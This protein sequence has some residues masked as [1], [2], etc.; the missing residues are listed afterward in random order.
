MELGD[1]AVAQ[2]VTEP[3]GD[4]RPTC[5]RRSA[6]SGARRATSVVL[7]G[8]ARH[9][10]SAAPSDLFGPNDVSTFPPD[11]TGSPSATSRA[12]RSSGMGFRAW[13]GFPTGIHSRVLRT[14]LFTDLVDSTQIA[15]RL[16]DARWRELLSGHFVVAR[17]EL[18]R[19]QR[20]RGDDNRRRRASRRSTAPP[21]RCTARQQYEARGSRRS[22]R[23]GRRPRRRGR[24][25]G[26]GRARRRRARGG[27]NHG[28]RRYR[29]DPRLRPHARAGEEQPD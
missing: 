1:L 27:P 21:G 20:A 4:G 16:G 26:R 11:T 14:L 6:A 12:S 23:P 29:R 15:S 8:T 18:E 9:R 22:P 2:I 3:A 5:G 10:V 17:A 13:T 19:F 28:R 24:A 25:G 7:S